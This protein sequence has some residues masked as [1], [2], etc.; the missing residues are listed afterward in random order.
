MRAVKATSTLLLLMCCHF[1]SS[2]PTCRDV[3][4]RIACENSSI[5]GYRCSWQCWSIFAACA[6]EPVTGTGGE[7]LDEETMRTFVERSSSVLANAS[8]FNKSTISANDIQQTADLTVNGT[9]ALTLKANFGDTGESNSIA[10][11]EG[12][13][14]LNSVVEGD[15]SE[16]GAA[17]A[18]K[19]DKFKLP[20]EALPI[21][22]EVNKSPFLLIKKQIKKFDPLKEVCLC[23][24]VNL[25]QLKKALVNANPPAAAQYVGVLEKVDKLFDAKGPIMKKVSRLIELKRFLTSVDTKPTIDDPVSMYSAALKKLGDLPTLDPKIETLQYFHELVLQRPMKNEKLSALALLTFKALKHALFKAFKLKIGGK[26]LGLAERGSS[27][28][29]ELLNA[30]PADVELSSLLDS[31]DPLSSLGFED[32]NRSFVP[33]QQLVDA[34]GVSL[35]D[36]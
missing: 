24:L 5:S 36:I 35:G 25:Q 26:V 31:F 22:D 17:N 6:C 21:L 1:A 29:K 19:S 9:E 34:L 15:N 14:P 27:P 33:L 30:L 4:T 16:Q 3:L 28:I 32:S 11:N 7:Q 12:F 20:V 23:L 2:A 8:T 18:T 13:M 10:E